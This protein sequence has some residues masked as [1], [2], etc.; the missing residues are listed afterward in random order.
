MNFNNFFPKNQEPNF[1]LFYKIPS[2]FLRILR[3]KFVLFLSGTRQSYGDPQN[4]T[5]MV[6][7]ALKERKPIADKSIDT[8]EDARKKESK[9]S[10]SEE[11]K[12][13]KRNKI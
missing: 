9:T 13:K 12:K 5:E 7:E 1:Q 8:K 3:T 4:L 10:E 6:R 11:E 2:I